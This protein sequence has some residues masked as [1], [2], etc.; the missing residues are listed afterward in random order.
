LGSERR[1]TGKRGGGEE[2]TGPVGNIRGGGG[3]GGG[4]NGTGGTGGPCVGEKKP[5]DGRGWRVQQGR[6]GRKQKK[7]KLKQEIEEGE[8]SAIS[9]PS[10]NRKDHWQKVGRI[11]KKEDLK[12]KKCHAKSCVRRVG[13]RFDTAVLKKRGAQVAH[14]R[15]FDKSGWAGMGLKVARGAA[16]E[17]S[18]WGPKTRGKR[19]GV[20]GGP[21]AEKKKLTYI[22]DR[23]GQNKGLLKRGGGG[24][25]G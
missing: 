1:C 15:R 7:K 4:P 9:V 3:G 10:G 16:H 5:Q 24:G 23:G 21:R 18:T 22:R 19:G 13:L 2:G 17:Q 6:A 8:R 20:R 25:G 11:V 12:K 14:S